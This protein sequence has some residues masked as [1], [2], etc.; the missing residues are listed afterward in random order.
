MPL[1]LRCPQCQKSLTV[2]DQ[3]AGRT[4]KCPGCGASFRI[5]SSVTSKHAALSPTESNERSNAQAG[6]IDHP[7]KQNDKPAR[8]EQPNA[9]QRLLFVLRRKWITTLVI[10]G[11]LAL[12]ICLVP[13]AQRVFDSD[14]QTAEANSVRPVE[15]LNVDSRPQSKSATFSLPAAHSPSIRLPSVE[16]LIAQAQEQI[17]KCAGM[18]RVQLACQL[19][20]VLHHAGR[21]E[22]ARAVQEQ[23]VSRLAQLQASSTDR[24]LVV[25]SLAR[26]GFCEEAL[27]LA[28]NLK[29]SGGPPYR[30]QALAAAIRHAQQPVNF[31]L[32]TKAY[33]SIE[34]GDF[35]LQALGDMAASAP[36]TATLK[37]LLD[38]TL[39]YR[40]S[41][42]RSVVLVEIAVRFAH[43]KDPDRAYSTVDQITGTSHHD[44]SLKKGDALIRAGVAASKA[45]DR[46][47]FEKF[48]P[49][50]L[51]LVRSRLEL[52]D[53]SIVSYRPDVMHGMRRVAAY[54]RAGNALPLRGKENSVEYYL[55]VAEAFLTHANSQAYQM[56]K[57]GVLLDLA[58]L[59][60]ESKDAT[61]AKQWLQKAIAFAKTK[62]VT[63][64]PRLLED[65]VDCCLEIEDYETA[66]T[67]A[68]EISPVKANEMRSLL[69]WWIARNGDWRRA[70][71]MR[72][73]LGD[74]QVD[75]LLAVIRHA[76]RDDW[77]DPCQDVIRSSS[78]PAIRSRCLIAALQ[79][80]LRAPEQIGDRTFAVSEWTM[81]HE[82]IHEDIR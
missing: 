52:P 35:R 69:P 27:V 48:Q 14:G 77:Y 47:T 2:P 33:R 65:V 34:S 40:P 70:E 3:L 73:S 59:G 63:Q 6:Q 68:S 57:I 23:I 18:Q 32:M 76:A 53:E 29:N 54:C 67:L 41:P 50:A 82:L 66:I 64:H 8:R 17:D 5:P 7:R 80:A 62:P 26:A 12:A 9:A 13:I 24:I 4:G 19:I 25:G 28:A 44:I 58:H 10:A 55:L 11:V 79:G 36:D 49:L 1:K 39:G 61:F 51:K 42:E 38:E 15:V 46:A 72:R 20:E 45:G 22:N 56:V 16:F 30:D 60:H 31:Q 81:Y 74:V 37:L 71:S 75:G 78:D 43:L 21:S